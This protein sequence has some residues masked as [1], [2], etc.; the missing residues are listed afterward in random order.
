[1][2]NH[3][4]LNLLI[5][6]SMTLSACA[7]GP[8]KRDAPTVFDLG[9]Q[10]SYSANPHAIAATFLIPPVSASPWLD[11]TGIQYRL[12]YQNAGRPDVY[13][14]N[15]WAMTPAQLLTERLRARFAGAARGV[16]TA[17]DGA[18]ADYTLRVELEDFSQSFDSTQS[19]KATVR[20]RASLI[21]VNTRVLHVQR[22]FSAERPAAPNAPGAVQALTVATEAVVEE[23]VAWAAQNLRK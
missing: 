1:M 6:Y 17:Q 23:L 15:R 16:V 19:S 3:K 13:G 21:D 8:E 20:L 5:I 10:R 9:P 7:L 12:L 18:K 14:Q 4:Y 22:G 11:H 2:K